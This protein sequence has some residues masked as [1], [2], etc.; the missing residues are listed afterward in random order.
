MV[1]QEELERA[2]LVLKTS[3]NKRQKAAKSEEGKAG[4]KKT[5]AGRKQEGA[6][7]PA[8]SAPA[9]ATEE[10]AAPQVEPQKEKSVG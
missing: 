4:A 1:I 6:E 7:R 9:N 8:A 2:V 10:K 3:R 5:R